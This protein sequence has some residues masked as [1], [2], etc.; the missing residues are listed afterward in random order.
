MTYTQNQV[1]QTELARYKAKRELDIAEANLDEARRANR[2][3]E[4]LKRE[5]NAISLESA[6][7]SKEGRVESAEVSAGASKYAADTKALTDSKYIALETQKIQND[8]NLGR[9]ANNIKRIVANSGAKLNDAQVRRINAEMYNWR[10]QLEL[11]KSKLEEQ[12]QLWQS[13]ANL[14]NVTADLKPIDTAINGVDK[15]LSQVRGFIDLGQRS[16]RDKVEVLKWLTNMANEDRKRNNELLNT[17]V[18]AARNDGG[19]NNG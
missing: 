4:A 8:F 7:L 11:E 15:A 9:E 16:N 13:Q 17:Y 12:K 19:N 18:N 3:Q 1:A 6:R 14:N 5:A 10:K 2:A